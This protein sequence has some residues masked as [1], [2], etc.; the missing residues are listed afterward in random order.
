MLQSKL[1]KTVAIFILFILMILTIYVGMVFL[2]DRKYYFIS[3]LIIIY[4]LIMFFIRFEGK[5]VKSRELMVLAVMI[6]IGVAGRGLTYMLPQCK[7]VMAIV[8]ISGAA[9]GCESGFL[10]GAL[11]AFA[12]NFFFGQGPW[13]PWQMFS[14]G[15]CGFLSG[16][17]FYKRKKLQKP[18][19]LAVF[20]VVVTIFIY[21]GI[22][23]PSSVL[24]S[25]ADVTVGAILTSYATGILSDLQ[26]GVSTAI[27]ILLISKSMISKI[28]RI[29][30]KY[31]LLI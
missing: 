19:L 22:M 27:F 6:S 29:K 18:V 12:S 20:G 31:G 10:V 21:G 26:H 11:I 7:P 25:Q 23:N 5:E 8:I 16:I 1:K 30:T 17:V 14:F 3:V 24:I 2:Q 13:T 28:E 9:F 15:L 4:T